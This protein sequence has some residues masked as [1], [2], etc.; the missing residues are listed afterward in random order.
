MAFVEYVINTVLD[1]YTETSEEDRASVYESLR[2][3]T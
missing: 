2:A 3:P 1:T